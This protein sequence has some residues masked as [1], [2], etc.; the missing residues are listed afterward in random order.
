MVSVLLYG[1]KT[2]QI[3][4]DPGLAFM[5]LS[6]SPASVSYNGIRNQLQAKVQAFANALSLD[7]YPC[8]GIFAVFT[9]LALLKLV[10]PV[11][12]T[13]SRADDVDPKGSL[14]CCEVV[15][16]IYQ[17]W[18]RSTSCQHSTPSLLSG[19]LP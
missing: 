15:E 5:L 8:S 18:R 14:P 1:L 19:L 13:D 17:A 10:Y 3:L 11:F 2:C 16:V 6:F 12:G 4:L 7:C 9:S